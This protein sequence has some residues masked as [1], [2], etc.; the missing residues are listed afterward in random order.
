MF[1]AAFSSAAD[2]ATQRAHSTCSAASL[3]AVVDGDRREA[4]LI[5][6]AARGD[7]HI[8]AVVLD[9]LEAADRATELLARAGVGDAHV[10]RGPGD[11]RKRSR[12]DQSQPQ[13]PRV[14]EARKR[15]PERVAFAQVGEP[16]PAVEGPR[17]GA[18]P[19][20]GFVC[21]PS[22]RRRHRS[23]ARTS[24][25]SAASS[26]TTTVRSPRR[27]PAAIRRPLSPAAPAIGAACAAPIVAST[28][29][30]PVVGRAPSR[31]TLPRPRR[32]RF[33]RPLRSP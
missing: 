6:G 23:G 3:R 32:G 33:L 16:E 30:P 13:K 17:R 2:P 24:T 28:E 27:K 18:A 7:G 21:G 9:G 20:D 15:L 19:R 5:A 29:G 1:F 26:S 22:R 8:R 31:S 4:H 14:I 12:I 11:P 10:E 25:R